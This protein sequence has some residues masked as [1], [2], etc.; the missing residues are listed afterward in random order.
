M[1]KVSKD[2]IKTIFNLTEVKRIYTDNP[3][4]PMPED[5]TRRLVE[6][7]KK[8]FKVLTGQEAVIVYS[9]QTKKLETITWYE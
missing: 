1:S 4:L 5:E 6:D 7:F 3:Y 8:V 2:S 9:A